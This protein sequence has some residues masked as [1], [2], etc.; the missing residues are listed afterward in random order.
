MENAEDLSEVILKTL[1]HVSHTPQDT[2]FNP[3]LTTQ[4]ELLVPYIEALSNYT[5]YTLHMLPCHS[6]LYKVCWVL[7]PRSGLTVRWR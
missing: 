3:D 7:N 1:L 5:L 4:P 6:A 2:H